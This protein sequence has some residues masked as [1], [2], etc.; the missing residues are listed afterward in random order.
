[1]LKMTILSKQLASN[2][3]NHTLDNQITFPSKEANWGLGLKTN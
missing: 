2:Y 1:M 3:E